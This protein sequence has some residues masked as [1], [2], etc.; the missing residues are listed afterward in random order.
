M[1]T[2]PPVRTPAAVTP[3]AF[4]RA[5]VAAYR[6]HGA[7]PAAWQAVQSKMKDALLRTFLDCGAEAEFTPHRLSLTRGSYADLAGYLVGNF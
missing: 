4:A 6:R 1:P 2:R 5:I 3:M 7:D